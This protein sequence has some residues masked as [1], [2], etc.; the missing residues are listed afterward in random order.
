MTTSSSSLYIYFKIRIV[1]TAYRIPGKSP[2]Q[3]ASCPAE[4]NCPCSQIRD[5]DYP[6]ACVCARLRVCVWLVDPFAWLRYRFAPQPLSMIDARSADTLV[7]LLEEWAADADRYHRYPNSPAALQP[8]YPTAPLQ[9]RYPT[10]LLSYSPATLQPRCPTA[11]RPYSPATLQPRYPIA[12][13]S[14]S[15]AAL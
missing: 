5:N 9:S 13:L 6:C 11:P 12:P 15:P 7:V 14:Y 3:P 10:A 1:A 2:S 4:T 8:C